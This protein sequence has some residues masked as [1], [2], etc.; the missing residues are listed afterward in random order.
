MAGERV[1][2]RR[3]PLGGLLEPG[4]LMRYLEVHHRYSAVQ[5]APRELESFYTE[6]NRG[7]GVADDNPATVNYR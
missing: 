7:G 5:L 1:S 3:H 4:E 2:P 6:R